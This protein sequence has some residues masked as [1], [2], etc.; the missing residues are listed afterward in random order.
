M[1]SGVQNNWG[2]DDR[3]INMDLNNLK[4]FDGLEL[5]Y[6]PGGTV[7]VPQDKYVKGQI[8]N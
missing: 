8:F 3:G 2:G 6:H 1:Y 5:T 7:S 4:L